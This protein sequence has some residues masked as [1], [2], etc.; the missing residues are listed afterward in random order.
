MID[1]DDEIYM[2]YFAYKIN[3]INKILFLITYLQFYVK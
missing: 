3:K 1:Y 2:I